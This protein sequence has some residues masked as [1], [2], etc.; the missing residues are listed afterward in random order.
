MPNEGHSK[1]NSYLEEC[2]RE[3][4]TKPLS[5]KES[6]TKEMRYVLEIKSKHFDNY[7]EEEWRF[8]QYK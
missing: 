1:C 3:L 5:A 2:E 8:I 4:E 7:T 6:Y